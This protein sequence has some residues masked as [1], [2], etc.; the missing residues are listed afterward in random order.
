MARQFEAQ[1][2]LLHVLDTG[3]EFSDFTPLQHHFG[4]LCEEIQGRLESYQAEVFAGLAVDRVFKIGRAVDEIVGYAKHVAADWIVMPTHGRTRFRELLLGSVTAGVLHDSISAVI[5]AAHAEEMERWEGVPRSILCAVDMS[6]FTPDVL[7]MAG[8]MAEKTG[9][10]LRVVHVLEELP[11]GLAGGFVN[12]EPL[13][14][15][16]KATADYWEF[17]EAAEVQTPLEI[18]RASN[19]NRAILEAQRKYKADLLIIG[20]GKMQGVL[21]RLRTGAHELIRQSATPVLSV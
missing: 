10:E 20:R 3:G 19:V 11:M 7:A 15:A 4:T 21:G 6:L 2:T 1:V 5:T 9:A 8:F 12:V 18:I 17:A 13:L 14:D 16:E